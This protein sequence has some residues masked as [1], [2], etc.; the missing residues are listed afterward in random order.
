MLSA[1]LIDWL[2]TGR[3]VASTKPVLHTKVQGQRLICMQRE[4]DTLESK[5]RLTSQEN[6]IRCGLMPDAMQP[7]SPKDDDQDGRS[8][9]FEGLGV[10]VSPAK[11]IFAPHYASHGLVGNGS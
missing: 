7:T 2:V 1:K 5:K 4:C 11:T 9:P 6:G 10:W 8:Q 3:L